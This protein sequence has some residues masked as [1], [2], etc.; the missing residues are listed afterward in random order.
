MLLAARALQEAR[1]EVRLV[2][3]A[4]LVTNIAVPVISGIIVGYATGSFAWGGIASV[5]L[6]ILTGIAIFVSKM[7]TI[8]GKVEAESRAEAKR[9]ENEHQERLAAYKDAASLRETERRHGVVKLLNQ[10]YVLGRDNISPAMMAGLELPPGIWLNDQLR[11]R[12]E[13][14]QVRVIAHQQQVFDRPPTAD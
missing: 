12:A 8:P 1:S 11:Q 13:N 7:F 10:F 4:N 6:V 9:I 3:A 2:S 5:G 14:F